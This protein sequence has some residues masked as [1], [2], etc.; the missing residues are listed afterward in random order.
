[1]IWTLLTVAKLDLSDVVPQS[2]PNGQ[3]LNSIAQTLGLHD[4]YTV[5]LWGY[6]EGYVNTGIDR[7]S[8]PRTFYWFNPVEIIQSQLLAGASSMHPG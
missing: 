6:C 4:Y 5:G 8:S 3:L 1:M 2:F 7:C